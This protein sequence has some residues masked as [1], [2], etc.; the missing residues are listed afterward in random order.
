[1]LLVQNAKDDTIVIKE[2]TLT[3]STGKHCVISMQHLRQ[4]H[5]ETKTEET[6]GNTPCHN[7]SIVRIM[8]VPTTQ[9]ALSSPTAAARQPCIVGDFI[10]ANSQPDQLFEYQAGDILGSLSRN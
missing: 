8:V 4:P 3:K 2:K 10:S 9:T 6:L 7:C 5:S 1:M